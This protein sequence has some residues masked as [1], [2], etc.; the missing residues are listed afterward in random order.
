MVIT[1]HT[2]LKFLTHYIF[3]T[4]VLYA[5]AHLRTNICF[6]FLHYCMAYITFLYLSARGFAGPYGAPLWFQIILG[7]AYCLS[8]VPHC[9][10]STVGSPLYCACMIYYF[11]LG[12]FAANNYFHTTSLYML[13][14]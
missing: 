4:F 9:K 11:Y 12:V 3:Q 1:L 2:S 8:L 7:C 10:M 5:M 14:I 13:I 6:S